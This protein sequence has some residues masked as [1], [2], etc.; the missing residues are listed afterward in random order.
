MLK[1]IIVDTFEKGLEGWEIFDYGGSAYK[2]GYIARNFRFSLDGKASMEMFAFKQN[3]ICA[4]KNYVD[5]EISSYL[6]TDGA[7]LIVDVYFLLMNAYG[8][9]QWQAWAYF[10]AGLGLKLNTEKYCQGCRIMPLTFNRVYYQDPNTGAMVQIAEDLN[11]EFNEIA[12][13][14]E[15]FQN[16][17]TGYRRFG[18]HNI[19]LIIDFQRK[20]CTH[21]LINNR[22][23]TLPKKG[24]YHAPDAYST[25]ATIQL[26]LELNADSAN[27]EYSQRLWIGKVVLSVIK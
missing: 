26:S 4:F 19:R 1:E 11:L 15:G 6:Q 17:V 10:A 20:E 13:R 22:L 8:L 5:P 25:P 14:D 7:E 24:L 27:I 3:S 9:S 21:F 23:F 12:M 18:W 2:T 16:L